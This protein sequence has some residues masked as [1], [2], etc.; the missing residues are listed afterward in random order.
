MIARRKIRKMF[1]KFRFLIISFFIFSFLIAEDK[2]NYK[3][4]SKALWCSAFFPGLG[5]FYTENYLKGTIFLLG[6][7]TLTY[8]IVKS[9]K[10]N[11][12]EKVSDLVWILAGLHIF[13]VADAY[14]SA[15]F[16]KFKEE[17]KLTLN[18]GF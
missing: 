13:N 12:K 5:Q 15:H 1:W 10:E 18:Y 14:I 6:E 11:K 7:A 3:S 17:T 8:F 2:K 4:P 9:Y 16:Y